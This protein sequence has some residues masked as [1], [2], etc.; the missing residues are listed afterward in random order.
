[1]FDNMRAGRR[2]VCVAGIAILCGPAA[3]ADAQQTRGEY[4]DVREMPTGYVGER[5]TELLD[6]VNSNDAGKVKSFV[7]RRFGPDF[8]NFAPMEDH[9]EFFAQVYRRSQGLE[10]YSVRKYAEETPRD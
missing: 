5:I 3:G 9:L 8:L 7:S 4:T 2:L 6:A 1:M 10:F